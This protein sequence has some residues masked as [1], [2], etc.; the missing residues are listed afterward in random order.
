MPVPSAVEKLLVSNPLERV[1]SSV[2]GLAVLGK[3]VLG[4][5]P[6]IGALTEPGGKIAKSARETGPPVVLVN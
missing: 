4:S 2:T 5:M 3:P 6:M 1:E